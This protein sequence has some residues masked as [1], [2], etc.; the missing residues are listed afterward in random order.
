[1][2]SMW[3]DPNRFR[4]AGATVM[5]RSLIAAAREGG[6]PQPS[7]GPLTSDIADGGPAVS[8]GGV[9]RAVPYA[10]RCAWRPCV[11]RTSLMPPS[12]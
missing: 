2:W 9:K 4:R 10:A 11:I 6:A 7:A 12:S 1:M 5:A 8:D 3:H